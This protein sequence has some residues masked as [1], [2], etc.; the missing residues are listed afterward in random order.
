MF[1]VFGVHFSTLISENCSS[2]LSTRTFSP[3]SRSQFFNPNSILKPLHSLMDHETNLHL[4]FENGE[5]CSTNRKLSTSGLIQKVQVLITSS[6]LCNLHITGWSLM[7]P[8]YCYRSLCCWK[9]LD[10][11]STKLHRSSHMAD[12]DPNTNPQVPVVWE[13][14]CS[15]VQTV[16]SYSRVCGDQTLQ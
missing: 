14:A 9:E 1:V 12:P 10:L 4:I 13:P 2:I 6:N 7:S 15:T 5:F 16:F 11:S 3:E 8:I